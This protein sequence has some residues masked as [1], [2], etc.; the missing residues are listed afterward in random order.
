MGRKKR[1]EERE[2]DR[3]AGKRREK[4]EKSGVRIFI[5]LVLLVGWIPLFEK[6]RHTKEA[7]VQIA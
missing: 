2:W 3:Q 4:R 6:C 5:Q 1:E 7:C